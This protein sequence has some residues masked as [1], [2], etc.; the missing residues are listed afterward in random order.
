MH[1]CRARRTWI[2]YQTGNR[3]TSNHGSGERE[4]AALRADLEQQH[5]KRSRIQRAVMVASTLECE[6]VM[7]RETFA[8][9]LHDIQLTQHFRA[10]NVHVLV[11][12][13]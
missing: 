1:N 12:T 2:L 10:S 8:A 9:R 13:T 5:K 3:E 11:P 4:P 7:C 6:H